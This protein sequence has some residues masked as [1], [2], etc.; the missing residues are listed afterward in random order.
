MQFGVTSKFRNFGGGSTPPFGTP[1]PNIE[2]NI[3]SHSTEETWV[4]VNRGH[5]KPP[6]VNHA[7]YHQI[8]VIINQYDLLSKRENYEL[9]ARESMGTHGCAAE[10]KLNLDVGFE[11]QGFVN[12]GTGV[13]TITTSAKIDNQHQNKM[14]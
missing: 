14:W 10:I 1:P 11:V 7:S 12:P 2:S 13:N 9:T 8:R 5:K 4:T 6:S 3:A